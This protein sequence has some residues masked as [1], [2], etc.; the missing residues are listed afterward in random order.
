MRVFLQAISLEASIGEGETRLGE[1]IAGTEVRMPDSL[2]Q[3]TGD[4]QRDASAYRHTQP[5]GADDSPDALWNRENPFLYPRL[6]SDSP[7]RGSGVGR[8]KDG[9]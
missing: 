6:V 2:P 9:R 3:S 5:S 1:F 8:L 7:F 4:D